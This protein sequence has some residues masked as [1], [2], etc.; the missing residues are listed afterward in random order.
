VGFV[1]ARL[2][3]RSRDDRRIP[4]AVWYPVDHRT[5]GPLAH[6]EIVPGYELPTRGV[7]DGV[8][9]AEGRHP[10][11]VFSHGS[12][13]SR[14]LSFFLT[15]LLASHGFI[16]VAP[17]HL[18]NTYFSAGD[19]DGVARS[20]QQRPKDAR[21]VLDVVLG[22]PAAGDPALDVLAGH[23]DRARVGMA[24]HSYGG[25]TALAAAGGTQYGDAPDPR[26]RAVA[27]LA[28]WST[29]L[30]DEHLSAVRVPLLLVGA[31]LDETT[32]VE[33][34]VH[35]PFE[36]A[37][38]A[39]KYRVDIAGADHGSFTIICATDALL[40]HPAIDVDARQWAHDRFMRQCRPD[41]LPPDRSEAVIDR[42]TV[43]FFR[44][45]LQ[46]DAAYRSYLTPIEGVTFAT[47]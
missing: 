17:D 32:P 43:A 18:G 27:G 35:R 26:V 44:V 21:F 46:G 6:Y 20:A 28:P 1:E 13:S 2:V 19:A 15:E 47:G 31:T 45:H 40:D 25:Y 29:Q 34:N 7:L 37:A 24:G 5:L 39:E 36:L 10:V 23:V 11:I 33:P 4:L 38:S 42:Y 12:G 16:V 41:V 8:P 3:D 9:A 14:H 22:D 30:T